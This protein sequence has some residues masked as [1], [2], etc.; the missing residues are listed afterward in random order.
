M[1]ISE[2]YTIR[3]TNKALGKIE[4]YK[5][6]EHYNFLME[7]LRDV[8]K[9]TGVSMELL[10]SKSRDR[11]ITDARFIYFRRAKERTKYSLKRIGMEVNRDHATVLH[12][13]KEANETDQVI[14]LYKKCYEKET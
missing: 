6:Y 3:Q 12:G 11:E 5:K 1:N 4:Q 13:I 9:K 2:A 8:S 7:I 14:E 10:Q